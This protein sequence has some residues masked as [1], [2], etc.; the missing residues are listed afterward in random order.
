MTQQEAVSVSIGHGGGNSGPADDSLRPELA[1]V[2]RLGRRLV[3]LAV[4]AARGGQDPLRDLLRGHLGPGAGDLPL[5]SGSWQAYDHVNVQIGL[6]AWLAR[7][8]RRHELV[9]LTE[10]RHRDFGLAELVQPGRHGTGIGIGNVSTVALPAGPGGRT[11][12]A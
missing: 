11:G 3:N 5:V 2:A 7:G 6:D 10:F 4:G 12:P 9:G 8:G 1:D